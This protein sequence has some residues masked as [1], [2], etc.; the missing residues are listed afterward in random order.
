MYTLKL[1]SKPIST[2]SAYYKRNRAF[3]ENTR[4]W[5]ANFFSELMR[6]SNQQ[7]IEI[8]KKDF[9]ENKHA[10]KV[11]LIWHQ[12]RSI[13]FTNDGKLSL[14]SMDVDN[15]LKIPIDCLFDQKYN[16]TWL[17]KRSGRE[18]S[19]YKEFKGINNICLNDKFIY[20]VSSIKLPSTDSEFH[21]TVNIEIHSTKNFRNLSA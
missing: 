19:L 18:A 16:D 7:V 11:E 6:D 3:N 17:D 20:N 12:P 1:K 8:I 9:N 5:R 14:R 10:L 2:N 4:K 15:C 21:L 13:L